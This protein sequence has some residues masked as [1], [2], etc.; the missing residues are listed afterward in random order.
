[1]K[2]F[3]ID[4][5]CGERKYPGALGIDIVPLKTVEVLADANCGLPFRADSVDGVHLNHVLEHLN[6]LVAAMDEVWRICKPGA[7]VYVTVPHAS[8][9]FMTW[10]DPTHRRGMNLSTLSYFDNTTFDGALFSYYSKANFRR[11]YGRLR[12][13][14]GGRAGRE[15]PGRNPLARTI[16]DVLEALANA[17]PY[18]QHLCERWWGNLI[19]VAEAYA[20]LEAVK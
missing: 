17:S 18:Q 7:R 9:A 15:R 8:S 10:R 12:F 3:V 5:G 16:T 1:M 20:V 6:D 11:V 14:A 4:I 13:A 2:R 19:G